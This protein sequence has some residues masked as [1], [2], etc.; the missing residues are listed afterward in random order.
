MNWAA[1][2]NSVI[3]RF[4][5]P[6]NTSTDPQTYLKQVDDI[7]ATDAYHSLSIEGYSVNFELIERVRSGEWNPDLDEND[8]NHRNVLAARGYWQAFLAVKK[9]L[10]KILNTDLGDLSSIVETDHEKWYRGLFTP[11]ITAGILETVDLAGYRNHPVYIRGS[12]YVPP[13]YIA[14]REL[15]P[16]FFDLLRNENEAAVRGQW[17]NGTFF[18]ERNDGEWRL[19]LD[20]CSCGSTR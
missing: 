14:V 17:S 6:P 8:R 1:M 13:N 4:P 19:S 16:A 2:R 11:S 9:S 18:N 10:E 12:M 7:Y 20:S 15:I 5:S 3:E